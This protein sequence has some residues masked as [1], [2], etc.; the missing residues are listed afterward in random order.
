[1]TALWSILILAG[2][3]DCSWLWSQISEL[4]YAALASSPTAAVA[5]ETSSATSDASTYLQS[6][7]VPS[8]INVQPTEVPS[9]INPSSSPSSS[10]SSIT[11]A[12]YAAASNAPVI[13]DLTKLFGADNTPTVDH[14]A[15]SQS[16][17]AQLH[18][19]MTY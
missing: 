7:Y 8:I 5:D 3:G 15:D 12:V 16:I 18:K 14:V 11:S 13:S 2:S 1:M 17:L 6:T 9:A 10:Y 4:I 19:L